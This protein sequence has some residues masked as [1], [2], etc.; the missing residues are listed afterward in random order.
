MPKKVITKEN[1]VN[2]RE[3]EK[4]E[5]K[6]KETEGKVKTKTFT[7]TFPDNGPTKPEETSL[8]HTTKYYLAIP[9]PYPP[10]ENGWEILDSNGTFI[11]GSSLLDEVERMK[12]EAKEKGAQF[13]KE[14]SLWFVPPNTPLGRFTT[15]I[16]EEVEKKIFNTIQVTDLQSLKIQIQKDLSDAGL[17]L[18][19]REVQIDA[20]WQNVEI[21]NDSKNGRPGSYKVSSEGM[22]LRME[23]FKH[24]GSLDRKSLTYKIP[25]RSES[26][27]PRVVEVRKYFSDVISRA[28]VENGNDGSVSVLE[29][30]EWEENAKEI[31]AIFAK[32]LPVDPEH[33]YLVRKGLRGK[34][35]TLKS[36]KTKNQKDADILVPLFDVHGKI[37]S[38]EHIPADKTRTKWTGLA[39]RWNASN[40]KIKRRTRAK[41]CF[42]IVSQFPVAISGIGDIIYVAEGFS[43]AA[44]IEVI[45]GNATLAAKSKGNI[46]PVIKSI[47]E[48]YPD[49]KF[50]IFA[51]NDL[52]PNL[53][54]PKKN[55]G[56]L[57]AKKAEELFGK[58]KIGI[59]ECVLSDEELQKKWSDVND[60]FVELGEE[61]AKK[62]VL[63][64]LNKILTSFTHKDKLCKNSSEE[65]IPSGKTPP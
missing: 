30:E 2:A 6:E 18:R 11:P 42:Y 62:R 51:D 26:L 10:K 46:V 7:D 12:N 15:F 32:A 16:A 8:L 21:F 43:S 41:G 47:L 19:G 39:G 50:I 48:V 1:I 9:S 5:T 33:P 3:V 40:E 36:P 60:V 53:K 4:S 65:V 24:K 34:M 37:W 63:P 13:D 49:K 52:G 38:I 55:E 17:D 56:L 25:S 14:K 61:E 22:N 45:T 31:E 64:Q 58:E 57:A 27:N 20:G 44:T 28:R 35:Y 54:N 23:C 29:L 59:V